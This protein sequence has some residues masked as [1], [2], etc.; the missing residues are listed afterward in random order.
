[1]SHVRKPEPEPDE[2][3]TAITRPRKNLLSNAIISL[4]IRK[5]NCSAL[6]IGACFVSII[7]INAGNI[8]SPGNAKHHHHDK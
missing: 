7:G 2:I 1:M 3:T 8:N 4:I 5:F 6:S